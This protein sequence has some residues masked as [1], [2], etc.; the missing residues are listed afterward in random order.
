LSET[1]LYFTASNARVEA[2]TGTLYDRFRIF[3]KTYVNRC[4]FLTNDVIYLKM[5]QSYGVEF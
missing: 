4:N 2:T 1:E 3:C 5:P